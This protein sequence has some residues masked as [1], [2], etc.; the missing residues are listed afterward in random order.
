MSRVI[1]LS[2]QETLKGDMCSTFDAFRVTL[3][4]TCI[5]SAV[6]AIER[7]PVAGAPPE[8]GAVALP[9]VIWVRVGVGLTA[10]AGHAVADHR[11]RIGPS[12][13]PELIESTGSDP[14]QA[15]HLAC[16]PGITRN[17]DLDIA[18]QQARRPSDEW[19][20]TPRSATSVRSVS[21]SGREARTHRSLSRDVT[22]PGPLCSHRV[23]PSPPGGRRNSA[24]APPA[25]LHD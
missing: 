20:R 23:R 22:P 17:I 1:G 16:V 11:A 2:I 7:A 14:I 10:I 3:S 24:I 6:N 4:R 15:A 21:T 8:T 18:R 25:R 12:S 13:A 19:R 9:T 5:P